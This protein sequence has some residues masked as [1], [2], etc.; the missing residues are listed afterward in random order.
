MSTIVAWLN[1]NKK[2]EYHHWSISE[3]KL[4]TVTQYYKYGYYLFSII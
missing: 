3:N 4:I 2:N 1:L